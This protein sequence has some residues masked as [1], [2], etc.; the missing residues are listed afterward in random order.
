MKTLKPLLIAI[1]AI[2]ALTGCVK[3]EEPEPSTTH[4]KAMG[5]T[6]DLESLTYDLVWSEE[7]EGTE[8]DMTKWSYETGGSGWGNNELQYYTAGEN[9]SVK[10][11]LLSIDI[12]KEDKEGMGFTSTRM[13]TRQKA[14]FTYG[15]FEVYAKMPQLTGTWSA[16]WMMP[17]Y[18]S[19]YGAWPKS[20]EIDIMESVGYAPDMVYGTVHTES[21]NHK[22][23]TQKGYNKSI[24]GISDEFHLYTVE[25]LPDQ[26][27]FYV[28]NKFMYRFAPGLYLNC[29]T[30]EQW[31]F[32]KSFFLILNTA[33]G[34]DWG[35]AKGVSETGWPQVM[36]VDYIRVYQ[37]PQMN[38]ILATK[39]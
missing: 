39:K 30:F 27:R 35:G 3:K 9:A 29:P 16:I 2:S 12:R 33:V 14:D 31:P 7:F 18:S 32:D 5:Y 13:V 4:C 25:W 24:S 8:V 23:G 10:D 26:I 28:D 38:A 11:G 21:F 36:Q 1:M 17:T 34:G 37:T 20:G 15:K 22:K 19:T 6:Y